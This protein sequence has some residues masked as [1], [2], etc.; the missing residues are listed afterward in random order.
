VA[1]SG[2]NRWSPWLLAAILLLSA[3]LRLRGLAWGLP[4]AEMPHAP[5]HPDETWAMSVLRQLD[6]GHLRLNAVDAHRE[7]T[8][9]YYLWMFGALVLQAFGAVST[10]LPLIAEYGTDY[11]RVLLAGRVVTA[12]LDLGSVALVFLGL[13]KVCR[14]LTAPT[15]GA[16]ALA[17]A[18]FEVV[19][20]HY[21]RTHIV[22]NFFLTLAIFLSLDLAVG[23]AGRR[24]LAAIGLAC[25]FA[26]ASK[27][28]AGVVALVPVMFLIARRISY[29]ELLLAIA[30]I[31]G[32]ALLGLF[33]ADPFLFLKFQDARA[34]LA[35]QGSYVAT[36]EFR[37][38]SL[39]DFSR[40][41]VFF[42][43]LIP[44]GTLPALWVLFYASLAVAF[45]GRS[46]RR[47]SI[48]LAL[49]VF[50][51]LYP[52]AKGYF[53]API[54]IRAA[55]QIFPVLAFLVG[56]AWNE[57]ESSNR[58]RILIPAVA[59]VVTGL[60]LAS[61]AYDLGYT[62]AMAHGDARDQLHAFLK[63]ESG[64]RAVT[65][66]YYGGGHDYFLVKPAVETIPIARV[67]TV[68]DTARLR[69]GLEPELDFLALTAFEPGNEDAVRSEI[70]FL[71]AS[72]R[73]R[74]VRVFSNPV[75]AFGV[76]FDYPRNPHD[77]QYPL[78]KLY[79]L[80]FNKGQAAL[81]TQ[82]E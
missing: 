56:L 26:A 37:W 64:S 45:V 17:I 9:A 43:Y 80:A 6:P 10:S 8:L 55:L 14:G 47:I 33:L 65:L 68:T 22:A 1:R 41:F 53:S 15:V 20:A 5:Y 23:D 36:Q 79:L 2:L 66:G 32:F 71:E 69:A 42:N 81:P 11:R 31:G 30:W 50:V 39:F 19:Y 74:L 57:L 35:E 59:P 73:Y 44:Y 18:P 67:R 12:A 61:L 63:A 60:L 72:G 38:H 54:F 49:F 29:R 16:L 4:T 25:G 77:L 58:R 62:A 76:S 75:R 28:P 78:P 70:R 21:M 7:G 34:A 82:V 51:F 24:R 46:T 13:H 48:P 52:M 27:Y 3:L 40:L